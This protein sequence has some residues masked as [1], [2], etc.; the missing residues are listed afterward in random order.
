M[1]HDP[2]RLRALL[3]HPERPIQLVVAG[4]SHPADDEG[5]RLIQ[6]LVEF[7]QEPAV[8]GRIV[9]LPNYDIGM[10]QLLYPG[11]DVWLNN[12]LRPLEACGTSG[13]K[14]AL[15]GVLAQVVMAA[16]VL[17]GL[18]RR[19]PALSVFHQAH[20]RFGTPVLATLLCGMAMIALALAAPVEQ[21]AGIT[22]KVLLGVFLLVNLSLVALKSR[23]DYAPFKVA[24]IAGATSDIFAVAD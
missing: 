1:L 18:G 2:E 5:K 12:P 7:S 4:K 3:T 19:S 20:P 24:R 9:F 17:F 15:N 14:A 6:R 10:A 21:L 23:S 8:Q 22:S 16:R 13:M 11:C